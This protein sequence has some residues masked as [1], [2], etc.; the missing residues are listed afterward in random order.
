MSPLD[1]FYDGKAANDYIETIIRD[2]ENNRYAFY[3]FINTEEMRMRIIKQ[4]AVIDYI[5]IRDKKGYIASYSSPRCRCGLP[6]K[7]FDGVPI[8]EKCEKVIDFAS[9]I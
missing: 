4:T 9:Y 1:I 7:C 2:N 6:I 3:S 8:C 5:E